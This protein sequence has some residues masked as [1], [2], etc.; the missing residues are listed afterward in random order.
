MK[1]DEGPSEEPQDQDTLRV[2]VL[3]FVVLGFWFLGR[4]RRG[5]RVGF[6]VRLVAF[7]GSNLHWGTSLQHPLMPYEVARI[8]E[9]LSTNLRTRG[10]DRR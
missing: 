10:S 1:R 8:C 4:D 3:I 5:R 7:L 2:C 6:R 9:I